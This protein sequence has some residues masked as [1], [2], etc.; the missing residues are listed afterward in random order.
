MDFHPRV[1]I[2]I[3]RQIRLL[4]DPNDRVAARDKAGLSAPSGAEA[5]ASPEGSAG[6]RVPCATSMVNSPESRIDAFLTP[7]ASIGGV[8]REHTRLQLTKLR[9]RS[10]EIGR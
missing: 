9:S 8:H 6:C 3:R 5:V 2:V 4:L 7:Q 1:L 10:P